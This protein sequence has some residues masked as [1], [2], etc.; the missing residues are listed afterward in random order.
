[1]GTFDLLLRICAHNIILTRIIAIMKGVQ[2]KTPT[3]FLH[4]YGDQSLYS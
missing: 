4:D 2:V 1:M 3:R